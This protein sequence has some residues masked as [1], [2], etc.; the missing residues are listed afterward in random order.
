MQEKKNLV[1]KFQHP[2]VVQCAFLEY[3]LLF[4]LQHVVEF[5]T[6]ITYLTIYN[7]ALSICYNEYGQYI[8]TQLRTEYN[9]IEII[10]STIC[11][12]NQPTEPKCL[13]I[14]IIL[15]CLLKLNYNKVL[16]KKKL[17]QK[18]ATSKCIAQDNNAKIFWRHLDSATPALP[19]LIS[20]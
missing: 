5:A 1:N 13:H 18:N 6:T 12:A 20:K 4:L 14:K 15:R 19:Q 16:Q 11:L 17:Q 2:F 9:M 7:T 3:A 10:Y 8:M